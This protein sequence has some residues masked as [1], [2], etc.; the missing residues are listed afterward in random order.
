[1]P[2]SCLYITYG[3]RNQETY[4]YIKTTIY[5][6]STEHLKQLSI[7]Q[8][9]FTEQQQGVE[10]A[11]LPFFLY[12]CYGPFFE[13][14]LPVLCPRQDSCY[15]PEIRWTSLKQVTLDFK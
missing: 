15:D 1:M 4:N 2:L 5:E 13:Q 10:S 8:K 6:V 12:I 3:A 9:H 11:F 7:M 14:S